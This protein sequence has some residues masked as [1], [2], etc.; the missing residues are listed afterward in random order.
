MPPASSSISSSLCLK[1]ICAPSDSQYSLIFLTTTASTSVP[2]CGLL[3]QSISASAPNLTKV[4]RTFLILPV[5]SLIT[6]LSFPSENV[7]APPSPNCT[8]DSVSSS[9]PPQNELTFCC[10]ISTLSPRS[11]TTGL[12]P[13]SDSLSAANIPAGP[14][15]MITGRFSSLISLPFDILTGNSY[16]FFCVY[17]ILLF[18]F[19]R[20]FL[21][22]IFTPF[23]DT[24][25]TSTL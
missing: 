4:S 14:N 18:F 20:S 1:S 23:F 10:L 5:G 6:V 2:I 7:P 16:I 8:L 13:A 19:L 24:R 15:P 25:F 12:K 3:E 22:S 17:N 11:Y 9:P 21:S